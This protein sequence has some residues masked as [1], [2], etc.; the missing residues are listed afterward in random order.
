[1]SLLYDEISSAL[2]QKPLKK[3]STSVCTS[4]QILEESVSAHTAQYAHSTPLI[5]LQH[6]TERLV[7]G[8]R[9][10][11]LIGA[12]TNSPVLL[13]GGTGSGKTLLAQGIMNGLF[14]EDAIE[15]TITPGMSEQDFVGVDF[16][17][18]QSGKT[19]DDALTAAKIIR[20]PG[21]VLNELN[22]TPE[23]LQNMLIPFLDYSFEYKSKQFSCGVDG[24]QYRIA[25]INEGSEYKGICSIDHALR[26]RFTLE[27]PFDHF[28]PTRND[29]D[30]IYNTVQPKKLVLHNYLDEIHSVAQYVATIPLSDEAQQYLSSLT[31][32]DNCIKSNTSRK[33]GI[34]FHPELCAGCH[35]SQKDNNMCGH[36]FAP[37]MRVLTN[38]K[39]CAQGLAVWRSHKTGSDPV[40]DSKDILAIGPFV[41]SGK[42]S[43]DTAW[44]HKQYQ[45]NDW[46]AVQH[47]LNTSAVRF[48]RFVKQSF[49]K[50]YWRRPQ[51]LTAEEKVELQTYAREV[52]AWSVNL[53][54]LEHGYH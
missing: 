25:T 17:A 14:G 45:G 20:A 36:V 24:Y 47:V 51:A 11:L 2:K 5:T 38:W 27:I 48:Q 33:K 30:H 6:G 28:P 44:V 23:L 43:L 13:K 18:M 22:R 41:C 19:L 31:G 29:R 40:V 3:Q 1:M 32:L 10:L 49:G 12:I 9:D 7:L 35:H 16:G 37:S 15:K 34:A 8:I 52:D 50:K 21:V 42:L 4:L 46:L 53:N 54:E 39:K 26:N